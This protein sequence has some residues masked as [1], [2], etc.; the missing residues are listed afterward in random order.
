MNKPII[1]VDIDDV[2]LPH[3]EDLV[4]WFNRTYGTS[5]TLKDNGNDDP[6]AWGVKTSKEAIRWVHT[7]FESDD[8]KKASPFEEAI[9]VLGKLAERYE[10]VVITARDSIIEEVSRSW[11]SE[12]F[13]DLIKEAHFTAFY[14]LEGRIRKKADVCLEIKA[15]YLIDDSLGNILSA[16]GVGVQGILFG[17]Y[18]WNQTAALP[19]NVIQ[20]KDWS[21]VLE[22]FN[23]QA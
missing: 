19:A 18:P 21:T 10:L 12:H 13:G 4:A 5:L 17:D 23:V 9:H 6:E 1:A 20:C 16:A 11:L 8:F 15:K 7:F 3:F 14:S 2:L 22:Y